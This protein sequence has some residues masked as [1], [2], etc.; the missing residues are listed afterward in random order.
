MRAT[1][2]ITNT[3]HLAL[4]GTVCLSLTG[5]ACGA[6]GSSRP[7]PTT[8][9]LN[10]IVSFPSGGAPLCTGTVVF[11]YQPG[12]LTGSDGSSV[13]VRHPSAFRVT[14]TGA[15]SSASCQISDGVLG[16]RAG[17]WHA[18]VSLGAYSGQCDIRLS[19]G[20]NAI[21]FQNGGC[22]QL[23]L[24]RALASKGHVDTPPDQASKGRTR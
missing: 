11:T 15:G 16:L 4:I 8:A 24:Q 10:S 3:G 13:P 12:S 21:T 6:G 17:G 19:A 7:L 1:K 23:L 14:P 18:A 22:I 9:N 20:S 5:I 2:R